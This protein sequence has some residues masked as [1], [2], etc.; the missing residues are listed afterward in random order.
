MQIYFQ[1]QDNNYGA[2]YRNNIILLRTKLNDY[3]GL[4][5]EASLYLKFILSSSFTKTIDQFI[6]NQNT[7]E[8]DPD[9]LNSYIK[10]FTQQ[11]I[12]EETNL[13]KRHNLIAM[14]KDAAGLKIREWFS[15]SKDTKTNIW[16]TIKAFFILH[17]IHQILK[18]G[19]MQGLIDY[20]NNLAKSKNF[21][22]ASNQQSLMLAKALDNACLFYPRKTICLPF[23][24]A[25]TSLH[26]EQSYACDFLIG[27]QNLPF[28]AHAWVEANGEV[29]NDNPELQIKLAPILKITQN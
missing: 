10:H 13:V 9:K 27:I 25:L 20:L 23:A 11:E 6:C 7:D 8:I 24:A 4:E 2:F 29:I 22:A 15:K 14:P 17:R 1:W 12:I 26:Y 16:F 21:V 18:K 3:A 19:Q 5:E 28:Y